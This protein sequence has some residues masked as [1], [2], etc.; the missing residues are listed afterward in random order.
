MVN[1]HGVTMARPQGQSG[2]LT[3]RANSSETWETVPVLTRQ[4]GLPARIGGVGSPLTDRTGTGRSRRSTSRPGE[5]ASWGRAAAET[6]RRGR[7]DAERSTGEYGWPGPGTRTSGRGI[8]Y[9]GQ[10]SRWAVADPGRRFDDL[11]N[12]VHDPATLRMALAR[13]A[14]N[15]GHDTPGVDGWTVAAVEE[16]VGVAGFLDNLR[17]QVRTARFVRCRFA[18]G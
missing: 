3:C 12:L 10:A 8:R 17:A 14:S 18:N 6:R 13:V 11:F 15:T 4:S 2:L 9:A 7:C 16:T 1:V 5:P